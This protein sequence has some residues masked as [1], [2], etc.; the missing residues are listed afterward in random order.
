[1][2]LSNKTPK[3]VTSSTN[4]ILIDT[5]IETLDDFCFYNLN[6]LYF[7]K[8][9]GDITVSILK[10]LQQKAKVLHFS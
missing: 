7:L 1:M 10:E 4:F 9:K 3:K 2:S 6:H 8:G 5:G